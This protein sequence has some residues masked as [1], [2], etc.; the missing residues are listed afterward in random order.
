M[1]TRHLVLGIVWL[2]LWALAIGWKVQTALNPSGNPYM[3]AEDY[4][5]LPPI[6]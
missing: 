1:T 3:S 6:Q 4:A 5:A 2:F